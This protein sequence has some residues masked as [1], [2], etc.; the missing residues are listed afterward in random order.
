MCYCNTQP[1]LGASAYVVKAVLVSQGQLIYC[2]SPVLGDTDLA[3]N[4]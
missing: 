4:D 3:V 2:V 1:E